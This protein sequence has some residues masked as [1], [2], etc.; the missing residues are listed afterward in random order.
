[1]KI[2]SRIALTVSSCSLM[3]C[4]GALPAQDWPQWR[5]A[6][7]DAKVTGFIAPKSWPQQ[8]NQKW[9]TTVGQA[10]ATPA[11]VGDKLYVFARQ[12][13][14]EFV[15]CLNATDGKEVW[16][17]NYTVQAPGAPSGQQHPGPRSSPV[18]ADGK[19]VTLGVRGTLSCLDAGKGT[20][21]W[22]KDDLQGWPR[23]FTGMSPLAVDGMCVAQLGG[24]DNG[25]IVAYDLATG[26]EKWKWT[27]EGPAYASP[28]L[29][30]VDG[31]KLVV[32][33]TDKSLVALT[34]ADGK[35]VWKTPFTASGMSYNAATPI[36][37]GQILI[38]CGQGRG[39]KA[40]KIEKQGDTYTATQVWSNPDLSPQ[41]NTPVLK[42]G[43]LFGLTQRGYFVC[44]NASTGQTD[45]TDPTGGRG[46]YGSI[47]D[48]GSVLLAL[49]P[50]S[51][52]LVIQPSDKE[53]TE[54]ASVKVA[55]SV[56]Y[57]YPVISGNRLFIE[58]R[59]SVTLWTIE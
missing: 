39:A 36:A 40:V 27:G 44:V 59:D 37:D 28:V 19:V 14:D 32:A 10:D 7:R 42:D 30:T 21:L 58:D 16:H 49:T 3:V 5:G 29:L 57:A 46:G 25:I 50:K 56:T 22:R 24:S 23:F 31:V 51:Q 8:F 26:N 33:E 54:V 11:L 41:F 53:Y 18:V 6:N 47:V 13:T 15:L 4:A 1:M 43:L 35:E 20:L 38:Y 12:D 9:K 2:P 55:D 17:N 45:W 48:A 52:L 34:A